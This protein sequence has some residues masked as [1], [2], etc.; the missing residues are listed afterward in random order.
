MRIILLFLV[1]QALSSVAIAGQNVYKAGDYAY[2]VGNEVCFSKVF[3]G[4]T[5]SEMQKKLRAKA[6][7]RGISVFSMEKYI[8]SKNHYSNDQ[9]YQKKYTGLALRHLN[10]CMSIEQ[11]AKP[12]E[13]QFAGLPTYQGA[14]VI[15]RMPNLLRLLTK[16]P[17]EKVVKY[18][19]KAIRRYKH[20]EVPVGPGEAFYTITINNKKVTLNIVKALDGTD[21]TILQ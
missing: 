2:L 3:P 4:I 10:Q 1:L 8:R 12:L 20:E 18:Y 9:S 7:K 16:D 19:L 17:Y 6:S 5:A 11:N 15:R 14:R 21:I 13:K